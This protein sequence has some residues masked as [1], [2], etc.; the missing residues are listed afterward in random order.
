MQDKKVAIIIPTKNEEEY[1][2]HLIESI[3]NQTYRNYI[4]IVSDANSMDRTREIAEKKNAIVVEGGMPF[5][6]RNNGAKKAMELNVDLLIFIDADIILPDKHFLEK[7]IDEF[8]TRNL[9]LA[10]TL[11]IPYDIVK[12]EIQISKNIKFR[13]IYSTA[14]IV[15]KALEKSHR[16]MFQVCMFAKPEVHKKI[17]GFK[18]LEYGEDS[19]YAMDAKNAGFKFGILRTVKKVLISPRRYKQKG[20]FKSG[21]PYF[22][23]AFIFGKKF[24]HGKTKMKYFD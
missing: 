14:N 22:L 2:P 6:G 7:A 19:K 21:V 3:E 8:Y 18:P 23:T 20:F 15:M 9:D 1:L 16:P 10:G 12:G 17:R 13:I 24:V 4:I 5:T 11:Q